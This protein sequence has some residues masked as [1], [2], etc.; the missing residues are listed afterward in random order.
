MDDCAQTL[1]ASTIEAD[2][3]PAAISR[4]A[5]FMAVTSNGESSITGPSAE[6]S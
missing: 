4:A 6:L 2:R 5:V 3:M 1:E